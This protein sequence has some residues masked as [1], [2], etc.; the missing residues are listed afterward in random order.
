M[1]PKT[2]TAA[3]ASVKAPAKVIQPD[4]FQSSELTFHQAADTGDAPRSSKQ[5]PKSKTRTRAKVTVKEEEGPRE[6][7]VGLMEF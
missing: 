6:D 3:G 2:A 1:P 7:D 5:T 4:F